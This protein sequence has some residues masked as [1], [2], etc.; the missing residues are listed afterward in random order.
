MSLDQALLYHSTGLEEVED[1]PTRSHGRGRLVF[2]LALAA[3]VSLI[4]MKRHRSRSLADD[5]D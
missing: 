4:G 5:R 3:T 2:I 1:T